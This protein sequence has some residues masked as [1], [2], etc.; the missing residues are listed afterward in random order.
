MGPKII[1]PFYRVGAVNMDDCWCDI[2]RREASDWT[3]RHF[4]IHRDIR[5][6]KVY[7][8]GIAETNKRG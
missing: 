4:R 3:N 7:T 2:Y 5:F 1:V 8:L 6:E